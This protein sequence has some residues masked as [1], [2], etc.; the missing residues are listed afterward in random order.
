MISAQSRGEKLTWNEASVKLVEKVETFF[1][2]ILEAMDP[3]RFA[4][5]LG[6][7]N[8]NR[9]R[10]HL[11]SRVTQGAPTQNSGPRLAHPLQRE[12]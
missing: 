11:L 7:K 10:E 5:V 1:P 4:K 8:I 6:T 9:I 12:P 3:A 2:R